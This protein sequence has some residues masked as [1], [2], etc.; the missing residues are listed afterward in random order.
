MQEK[1]QKPKLLPPLNLFEV[2]VVSKFIPARLK[3]CVCACLSRAWHSFIFQNYSWASFPDL[4]YEQSREAVIE[5]LSKFDSL[6][7][8]RVK[9]EDIYLLT[10]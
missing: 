7:G 1:P 10:D 4:L 2:S 8:I 5:F 3:L 6:S 9:M